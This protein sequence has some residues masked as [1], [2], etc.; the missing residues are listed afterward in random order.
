MDNWRES[1]FEINHKIAESNICG[2]FFLTSFSGCLPPQPEFKNISPK[3]LLCC[4]GLECLNHI[5]LPLAKNVFKCSWYCGD[6]RS[7]FGG[8][9]QGLVC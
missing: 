1:L 5:C 3:V 2:F 4:E 6:R 7:V 8:V 9:F